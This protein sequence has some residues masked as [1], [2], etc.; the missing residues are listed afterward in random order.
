MTHRAKNHVIGWAATLSHDEST[1]IK[2]HETIA[3]SIQLSLEWR[4]SCHFLSN[5]VLLPGQEESQLGYLEFIPPLLTADN[6][7][8]HFQYAY[9]ACALV[10]LSGRVGSAADIERRALAMYTRALSFTSVALRSPQTARLDA[11]LAAVY[12][13]GLFENITAKNIS[14]C[15]LHIEGAIQ[16]IITRGQDQVENEQGLSLC[17]AV[18]MQM[19]NITQPSMPVYWSST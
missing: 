16:L 13:L 4:A 18:Q 2:G 10:S 9:Y 6:S 17:I 12:L 7:G 3:P 11:T 8:E 15:R 19:V 14:A 1:T 5:Y